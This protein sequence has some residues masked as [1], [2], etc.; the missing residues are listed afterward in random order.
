MNRTV[1][2]LLADHGVISVSKHPGLSRTLHRLVADGT[3]AR[4]LPGTFIA[5]ES[6]YDGWLRAVT[7]W[8]GR[9]ALH[10]ATA[11]NLW[12]G[13]PRPFV[14]QLAHP[15]LRS[16]SGVSVWRYA[17]EPR[18]VVARDGLHLVNAAYASVELAARDDGRAITE[19]LRRRMATVDDILEILDSLSGTSG[20]AVRRCVVE[21]CLS[22]PW[23][24]AE[25]RLHRILRGAG[26]TGWVGNVPLRVGGQVLHPDVLFPSERVVIEFDGRAFHSSRTD[27]RITRSRTPTSPTATSYSASAGTTSAIRT[28]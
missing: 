14:T 23:S 17:V 5:A 16:R 25:L 12:L 7:A 8:A 27:S 6:G 4:P 28:M 18:F 10:G 20:Q 11:A 13:D 24:Y 15:T 2:A 9:G 26:I 1:A 19:A 3:L 21:S 22:N